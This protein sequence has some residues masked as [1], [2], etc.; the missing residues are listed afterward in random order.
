MH[1]YTHSK[2]KPFNCDTCSKS[3]IRRDKYDIIILH[4]TLDK[5]NNRFSYELLGTQNTS[6]YVIHQIN[7]LKLKV[8]YLEICFSQT[9]K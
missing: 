4:N 8:N 5:N 7:K 2:T 1:M 6:N 3:F 9:K